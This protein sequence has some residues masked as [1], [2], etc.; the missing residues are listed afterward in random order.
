MQQRCG[1]VDKANRCR[2]RRRVHRAI[3]LGRV[4]PRHLLF[5]DHP[6]RASNEALLQQSVQEIET[7]E[8]TAAQLHRQP[9]YAAPETLLQSVK[10]LVDSGTY[11]VFE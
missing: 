2:C 7:L 8:Y 6:V 11:Q 9:D 3:E 10:A 5:A 4:D 1:L